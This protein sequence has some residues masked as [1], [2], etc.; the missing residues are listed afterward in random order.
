ME[1][2]KT[3]YRFKK[4]IPRWLQVEVRRHVAR[5]TRSIR[6]SQW[7]IDR[8]AAG[9]PEGFTGWPEGKKFALVLRH[10][11]E[12]AAG[13][14]GCAEILNIERAFGMRSAFFFVPADYVVRESMRSSIAEAGCEVAVHGLKHDGRL[15]LSRRMFRSQACRI[16]EYLREWKS[17]GFASPSSHHR[18]DWLHELNILY[19]SSSFDTD[20]F[21]PQPDGVRTIFPIMIRSGDRKRSFV[22]LPYT[23]PQ[24]FTLFVILQEESISI[25][26]K[27]LDWVARNGGM[28]LITTHPDYMLFPG[29]RSRKFSYPSRFYE[30]LLAYVER[31]YRGEYWMAL[32]REVAGFWRTLS[33]SSPKDHT[34][35]RVDVP[36]LR[37]F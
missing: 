7:P 5:A 34:V 22:E 2:Y 17:V 14:G 28:V 30:E 27:K 9:R 19:D 24:D 25:W 26:K 18:F 36:A 11:V 1:L 21:E 37:I 6:K 16:N 3:Y 15:Y 13:L 4:V 32:P 35:T 31:T 33:D 20:P 10:D 29:E 12:T 8:S 23:L